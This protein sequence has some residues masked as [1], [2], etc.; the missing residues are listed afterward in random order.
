MTDDLSARITQL[1]RGIRRWRATTIL[2]FVGLLLLVLAQTLFIIDLRN[3]LTDTQEAAEAAQVAAVAA[4]GD[5]QEARRVASAT[6]RQAGAVKTEEVA[7]VF[8]HGTDGQYSMLTDQMYFG[9]L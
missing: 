9:S 4:R 2:T 6:A 7:I 1:Q 5:A 3:R 8:G